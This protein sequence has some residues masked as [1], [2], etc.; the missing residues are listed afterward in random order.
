M[1]GGL[2]REFGTPDAIFNASL[3]ALEGQRPPA[4]VAQA[5]QSRRPLSDP[6]KQLA[7]L[8]AA[9]CRLLT[10]DEPQYPVRLREIY[11]PPPLL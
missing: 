4:A 9:G 10:W 7:Q 2:L 11:D 8:Q 5:L 1:A 6:A 3:T